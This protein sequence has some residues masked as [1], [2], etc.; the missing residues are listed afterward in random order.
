MRRAGEGRADQGA[1]TVTDERGLTI[2]E[3]KLMDDIW[4]ALMARKRNKRGYRVRQ[5]TAPRRR[6][7]M[8]RRARA[9]HFEPAETA[10]QALPD[11]FRT[12]LSADDTA[13][14]DCLS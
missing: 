7:P 4:C 14:V 6:R 8:R 9:F 2:G 12:Y 13:A 5:G 3:I 10:V 1:E 11:S